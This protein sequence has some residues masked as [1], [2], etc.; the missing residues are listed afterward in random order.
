MVCAVRT[1]R[2]LISKQITGFG[3]SQEKHI[4]NNMVLFGKV[5][6]NIVILML[7]STKKSKVPRI[8]NNTYSFALV[9]SNISRLSINQPIN[10]TRMSMRK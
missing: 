2:A 6:K 8:I 7:Q 1:A 3:R 9:D 5:T 4:A 10:V